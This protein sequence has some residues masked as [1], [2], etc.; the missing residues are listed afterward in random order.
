NIYWKKGEE[1][2]KNRV[3]RSDIYI[4]P[5]TLGCM[6]LELNQK[7]ANEMI[8][9]ALD[10]GINHLDTADLYDF[11]ENEKMIGQIVKC[12]RDEIIITTKVGNRFNRKSKSWYWDPSRKYIKQAVHDSLQRLK[13]DYI[14]LYLLHGGTIDDPIDE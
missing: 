14:D 6:S 5:L 12:K 2:I 9:Y 10:N 1:M 13:T 7:K 8:H 3:G 11:G 4:S